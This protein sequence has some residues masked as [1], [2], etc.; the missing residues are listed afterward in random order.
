[1]PIDKFSGGLKR[2]VSLACALIHHPPL[3][4]LDEP[5]VGIDPILR[6][7]IL[8]HLSSLSDSGVT[9]ILTTHYL[10]EAR[11]A[12]VVGFLRNGK[13]LAEDKPEILLDKFDSFDLEDVF[14]KL[15]NTEDNKSKFSIE[16][17]NELNSGIIQSINRQSDKAER[18]FDIEEICG[19]TDN[20][21]L[22]N[23]IFD[24][25]EEDQCT[26]KLLI[27][28]FS[29]KIYALSNKN[30]KRLTR[31]CIQF[32]FYL[33][34]PS[35]QFALILYS[36]GGQP[37][38]LKL[39]IYNEETVNNISNSWGQLFIDSINRDIFKLQE[40][41]SFEIALDSVKSGQ[42]YAAIDINDRFSNALR[43]LSIFGR[44]A[45][46]ETIE[47]S[48]IRVHIDWTNQ[49]I[50]NMI[51]SYLYD[52]LIKFG[53]L[54]EK[55]NTI[56]NS[57]EIPLSFENPIHGI[58]TE[59]L[60]NFI[61]PSAFL[62]LF[63]YAITTISSNLIL[64]DQKD[65]LFDRSIVAG[66]SALDYIVSHIV[67]QFIIIFLQALFMISILNYVSSKTISKALITIM[68]LMISQGFCG[69]AFGMMV[70]IIFND[71]LYSSIILMISLFAVL[72]MSG[73]FWPIV[74][75]PYTL[76]FI[77]QFLP[78]TLPIQSLRCILH[79]EWTFEYFE[80]YMGFVVTYIWTFIF[81]FI[82]VILIRRKFPRFVECEELNH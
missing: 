9:V 12:N 51:E 72:V 70:A 53:K 3:L 36:V 59:S 73:V 60:R 81:L 65:G 74:N 37:T 22:D 27:S 76:Q 21:K 10:E 45:D 31:K 48:K 29:N 5:T 42:N 68:T 20:N 15:C 6:R 28:N 25:H 78:S 2:R 8:L 44:D 67:L 13:I 61:L 62:I 80:V 23:G 1:M 64:E 41:N 52:A 17:P 77:G 54:V 57:I 7:K 24:N 69:V 50:G 34:F 33:L 71:L 47:E 19:K 56:I 49:M 4:I 11:I 40:F 18:I 26:K 35:I 55:S 14:Y 30:A 79:R 32:I 43:L 58:R 75:M 38:G 46:E 16:V 63:F 82:T 66:I 39:A